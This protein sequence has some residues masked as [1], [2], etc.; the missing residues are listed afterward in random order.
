MANQMQKVV[1]TPAPPPGKL[2]KAE[3]YALSLGQVIGVGVITLIG[4]MIAVTGKSVWLAYLA[5]VVLGFI[6]LIPYVFLTS[7][8]RFGGGVYSYVASTLD[9]RVSGMLAVTFIP[10]TMGLAG[11]GTSF[12]MYFNSLFPSVSGKVAGVAIILVFFV[13]NLFGVN[14]MSKVQKYATWLLIGGLLLFVIAGA[15]QIHYPEIFDVMADDFMAK[16]DAGFTSAIATFMYS[17]VG[18]SLVM[19]YGGQAKNAKR[20]LPWVYIATALSLLVLYV[21]VAIV[22]AGVLPLEEVAGQSMVAVARAILPAPLFVAFII[23]GPMMALLTTINASMIYYQLP[24]RQSCRDGWLP[25]SWSISN[26]NGACLPILVFCTVMGVLPQIFGFSIT[27]I[28]NNL[29]LLTSSMS[30]VYFWAFFKLPTKYPQAWEKSHLHVN[31]KA[32]YLLVGVALCVQLFIFFNACKNL[33]AQIVVISL[34]AM[35]ACM[36]YGFFRAKSDSVQIK[37]STWEE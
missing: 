10:T 2:G 29:Q 7:T 8:L 22:A 6:S 26:K 15:F 27:T 11:L 35:V 24:F 17:T 37:T 34:A 19:T 31:N 4:P 32:Y 36:A 20:D 5:A 13:I 14:V 12:G 25:E 21:G 28:T 33:T 23:C 18:Y 3:L 16:G 30:F 9:Y 1:N